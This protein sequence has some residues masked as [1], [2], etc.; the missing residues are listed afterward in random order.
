M[1]AAIS[2]REDLRRRAAAQQ[3]PAPS[4]DH[5]H[6]D[7]AMCVQTGVSARGLLGSEFSEDEPAEQQR[8]PEEE[9]GEEKDAA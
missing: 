7:E 4:R 9:H 1:P 5:Q 2:Q 6:P 3:I 8:G